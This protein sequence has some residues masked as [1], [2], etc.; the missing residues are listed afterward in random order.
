ML[1]LS[2]K[3]VVKF[4]VKEICK[5]N[6]YTSGSFTDVNNDSRMGEK[7]ILKKS[8]APRPLGRAILDQARKTFGDL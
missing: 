6:L 1:F 7:W 2:H 8:L 3:V 5:N 4:R